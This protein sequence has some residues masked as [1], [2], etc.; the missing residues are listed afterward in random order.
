VAQRLVRTDGVGFGLR[1]AILGHWTRSHASAA[2]S[3]AGPPATA[4]IRAAA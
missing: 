3:R 4:R 1:A 2:T